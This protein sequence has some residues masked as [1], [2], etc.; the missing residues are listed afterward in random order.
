[1]IAALIFDMDGVLADNSFA[2]AEAW[3]RFLAEQGARVRPGF[4]PQQTFG[5]RNA[6]LFADAFLAPPPPEEEAAL[7]QRL[8]DLY[9]EIF[10]P[11]VRPLP[12]LRELLAG[13]R[14]RGLRCALATSAPPANVTKLLGALQLEGAFAPVLTEADVTRGKPDPEIYLRAAARLRRPPGECVVF[15]DAVAGVIAARAA[16]AHC[17]ALTT[18]YPA[19]E[20]QRAGAE[21]IVPDFTAPALSEWLEWGD[22][23]YSSAGS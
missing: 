12:G 1:M 9:W 21:L 5:R 13:A 7:A 2:H 20:L 23:V 10:E 22:P 17:V 6:E 3:G 16:G 11:R 8:E 19:A 14:E 4:S 18:T 15:E